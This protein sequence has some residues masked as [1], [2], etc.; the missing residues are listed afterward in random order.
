MPFKSEAQRRKI[1]ELEQEGKVPRGTFHEWSKATGKKILP[2]RIGP[3][4]P[5][6]VKVIK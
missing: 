6:K 3:K 1:A 4:A 5:K 2:E